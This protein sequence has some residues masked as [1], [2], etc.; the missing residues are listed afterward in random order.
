MNSRTRRR[1]LAKMEDL[2]ARQLLTCDLG[3]EPNLVADLD[4]DDTV[5]FSD[6]LLLSDAFG[7]AVEPAGS[8]ADIDGDGTVAFA[9]FLILSENY[10][11]TSND[12]T[13]GLT[14]E[15]CDD[16]TM[17]M[18]LLGDLQSGGLGSIG[19]GDDGPSYGQ[20]NEQQIQRMLLQSPTDGPFYM[21]N[22]IEFRD[23][24]EYADGRETNLTGREANQLYNATPYIQAIGGRPV[25]VGEVDSTTLGVDEQWGQVAIV[26]YP[27]PAAL[28][29]M[30]AHPEFQATSIHKDAGLAA[31]TIMVTHLEPLG[32]LESPDP[33]T[34]PFPS[35][36]EDPGFTSVQVFRYNEEAQ[37]PE[38]S[39]EPTRTGEEA[40]DLY[41]TSIQAAQQSLGVQPTARLNVEGVFIGDGNDWDEV[42]IDFVPSNAAYDALASD[43]TVVDAQLHFDA[44]VADA[45]SLV[46]AE[47]FS[48][49]PLEADDEG[50][51]DSGGGNVEPGG[52]TDGD[53]SDEVLPSYH[54]G[55]WVGEVDIPGLPISASVVNDTY[56]DPETGRMTVYAQTSIANRIIAPVQVGPGECAELP[57]GTTGC[58]HPNAVYL[59]GSGEEL[60]EADG[61]GEWWVKHSWIVGGEGYENVELGV[62]EEY[63]SIYVE[64]DLLED[65]SIRIGG[66][67]PEDAGYFNIRDPQ[68]DASP[69]E[70]TV[71]RYRPANDDPAAGEIDLT[72]VPLPNPQTLQCT[73][74][75]S[76]LDGSARG[77]PTVQEE[78]DDVGNDE[79]RVGY[80]I[81]QVV[82]PTEIITWI[83]TDDMTQE[84]FDAIDLPPGW[85]KNQPREVTSDGGNFASSPGA[86]AGEFVDAEHFGHQWR[87]VATIVE[88][89]VPLDDDALLTVNTISKSHE[90]TFDAGSTLSI[91]ISPEDEHY[92][93]VSRDA[94]RTSD[95][96]TIPAGWHLVEHTLDE[97]LTVSLPNPTLNIRADN[98]DSFQGPVPELAAVIGEEDA[99]STNG[100]RY[101]ELLGVTLDGGTP[102]AEVWWTANPADCT[103]NVWDVDLDQAQEDLGALQIIKNGPRYFVMDD[104]ERISNGTAPPM[105]EVAGIQMIQVASVEAN[106]SQAAQRTPYEA[107]LVDRSNVFTY[108]VGTEV[109]ELTSDKGDVYI[110]QSYA[111]IVDPTLTADD[112]PELGSRLE[113][114]DGW[115]YTS[116]VLEEPIVVTASEPIEVLQDELQNSYSKLSD[117]DDDTTDPDGG[118]DCFD[119]PV[120]MT[121]SDGT[122]FVRTPDSCFADLPDWPYEPQYVEIDGLRQAYVDEGPEDGPV[123]LL[124]HG[125]PSWSYLYRDMIPVLADAGYRVIAM[126]H[127][128][129][130][131]SDKPIDVEDYS[132]LN[133]ADR[134]AQFIQE[135]DLEDINLFA[136]DWG[137]IIGLHVAGLNPDW[138]GTIS[139]GNGS[140]P[141]IPEG[142]QPFPDVENPDAILPIPSPFANIPDQQVPFYDEDGNLL[143]EREDNSFFGY[144]INYAMTGES[145]HAS[146]VLEALTWFPLPAEEEAAYDAP[147]PSRVYMAGTRSFP[148]LV[149]DL[150]GVNQASFEGLQSYENPFLTIWGS[151]DAGGQGSL[152]AQQF[153]I[154]NVPGAEGQPH[155]RLPESSHFLQDD[156]GEEIATRLV[157]FYEAN[158]IEGVET[159]TETAAEILSANL[160]VIDIPIPG[161][162]ENIT[163]AEQQR[164]DEGMPM[165][166]SV[167]IDATTLSAEDFT[168]TTASGATTKPTV[169]TLEPAA[170]S[171]ESRTVLLAGPLGSADDLPVSV[172]IVGSVLSV[173]GEELRGLTSEV[174]TNGSLLVL[175]LVDPAETNS[176]GNETTPT[177]IQLTFNGGVT[178]EFNSE[179]GVDELLAFRIYDEDGHSHIPTGFEDLGDNDNHVVLLVPPGVTPASVTVQSNTLFSPT[180]RP[181]ASSSIEVTGTIALEDEDEGED[182]HDLAL[183][184]MLRERQADRPAGRMEAF[185]PMREG[186]R[187]GR[188]GPIG[189]RI[190][191]AV[192]GSRLFG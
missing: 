152:E 48:T 45:Y 37:Y 21:V 180:N 106:P 46:I 57:N 185:F 136:Q 22:L 41:A 38:G 119:D 179:L 60:M 192:F 125:Q 147:F 164:G 36:D 130:G 128:G 142:G 6:F 110:M 82:S 9:D 71:T 18:S 101:C 175:A 90:L 139:I 79:V 51:I 39:D 113:L 14:P 62:A 94:G 168:I 131:R 28:F 123:V 40:M 105:Q 20:L 72:P 162:L 1:R 87:H 99:D 67:G 181:N 93:L 58:F 145:F 15:I 5:G 54:D 4:C 137:S 70:L 132:F 144:W 104:I 2:E 29:S 122:E 183:L 161:P 68:L 126:D 30:S 42:W 102:S 64:G 35:T 100:L 191:D 171:D 120:I 156:Q 116:R 88:A 25:F 50:D 34:L 66:V 173:D 143:V 188:P 150:P 140:L 8:G 19:L 124:L 26:E 176:A 69:Y 43:P 133:H 167:P 98:E 184:D 141:V 151:N 107:C 160:G 73:E 86:A 166:F 81:L 83:N 157:E 53:T 148:S 149:N 77:C 76:A 63:E 27:C 31:S 115:T 134:L 190:I 75:I 169:A 7:D 84:E 189:P 174:T 153:F 170:E 47:P 80:E 52:G 32:D 92:V 178:G 146:E 89:N 16:P 13:A 129:M 24:A 138:F 61:T 78:P 23:Q 117:G 114:P 121:A 182:E 55:Y 103:P 59:N 118:T 91:L 135:L 74:G 127:L 172:E 11:R 12:L 3:V 96:P 163:G 112:L 165:V 177:R 10:G 49:F 65:G 56:Y 95:T 154:D 97:E 155:T 33:S 17:L 159:T 85:F 44:A 186:S 109:Y 158:G 108:D 187:P 111:Q